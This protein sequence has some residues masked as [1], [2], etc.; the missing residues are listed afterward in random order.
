MSRAPWRHDRTRPSARRLH[1][2]VGPLVSLE[3]GDLSA[4]PVMNGEHVNLVRTYDP[5]DNAI[6]PEN[7]FANGWIDVFGNDPTRLRIVLEAI[8]RVE[9]AMDGDA[10]VVRR[11]S[12]NERA[13]RGQVGLSALGPL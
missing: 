11:V 13:N 12:F 5:I 2:D 3:P 7:N 6:G 8:H 10:R 1:L 4:R 9:D